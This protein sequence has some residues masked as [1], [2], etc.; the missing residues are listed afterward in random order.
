VSGQE[1]DR[2]KGNPSHSRRGADDDFRLAASTARRRHD[3]EVESA[4][5]RLRLAMLVVLA[6]VVYGT[7][8]YLLLTRASFLEALYMTVTTIATV[9]YGEIVPLSP[10]GRWFTL[11]LILGGVGR[12]FYSLTA[13]FELVLSEQFGSWRLWKRMS[14]DIAHMNDHFIICG[15]GRIG[16]QIVFDLHEQ[17]APL[18]VVDAD[19]DRCA[20]LLQ[21][22]LPF[23]EGDATRDETLLEAGVERARGLVAVLNADADNLMAVVTARGLNPKLYIVARAALPEAEKKLTRAGASEVISPYVV[24]ARRI[25]LSLLRPTVSRFLETLLFEPS[26]QGQMREVEIT[27]GS[28]LCGQTLYEAGFASDRG[29][30]L[31]LA[32]LRDGQLK[33]SPRPDLR[34]QEGDALIV[35]L[36]EIE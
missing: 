34:L 28:P 31:A 12:S 19:P 18:I 4:F 29:E 16:R 26:L 17:G 14:R 22:G 10:L 32:M 15:F 5:R 2:D 23:V 33:F 21:S 13:T 3:R 27:S 25:S 30:S 1:R 7:S 11:T 20:L 36:P 6:V 9:G 24:G 35:V 8:G